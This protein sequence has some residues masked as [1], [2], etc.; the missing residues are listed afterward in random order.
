[1]A[2]SKGAAIFILS[3]DIDSLTFDFPKKP[4]YSL[5]MDIQNRLLEQLKA[6]LPHDASLGRILMEDLDLSRDSAYRRARG[7]TAL[8]PEE[9][10]HLCSKYEL[11][12]DKIIGITGKTVVFQYNPIQ[13]GEFS[14]EGYLNG[15]LEGFRRMTAQR[16]Q[17]L[18]IS[19]LDLIVFQLLNF[20]PLMRFK[21]LYFAKCYLM[22]P[23]LQEVKFHKD[24]KEGISNEHLNEILQK[25]IR[26]DS[27]EVIG[28]EAGKGLVREIVSFYELGHF[29]SRED[30]L[31]L[32]DEVLKLC[33][34]LREQAAIG[35]KFIVNQPVV[36]DEGN[37][38]FHLH[39]TYLQDNTFFAETNA[40]RMLYITHNMINY[41]YTIDQDYV[42]K[43]FSVFQTMLKSCALI[44]GE[45]QRM[46]NGFFEQLENFVQKAKDRISQN[47]LF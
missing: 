28:F 27:V 31:Y 12:I 17:K 47:E 19:N 14:F 9:I 10:Q 13:R 41:L 21:L 44:S 29:E 2:A 7:E 22:L 18:Y 40:Y 34:H 8:K 5:N 38:S 23:S 37:F 6:K 3:G 32:L 46:R 35:R 30:A 11:S 20:P 1:M 45:N 26:T 42:N 43:S 15:I 36:T 4:L 24:W 39:Q 33:S 16:S 25:Y